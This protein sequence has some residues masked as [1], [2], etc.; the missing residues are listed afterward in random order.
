MSITFIT[1]VFYTTTDGNSLMAALR[2]FLNSTNV[3]KYVTQRCNDSLEV[4]PVAD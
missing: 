3:V 1:L 4:S 2:G